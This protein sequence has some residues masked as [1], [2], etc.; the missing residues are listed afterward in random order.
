MENISD[1]LVPSLDNAI[2]S[3]ASNSHEDAHHA[4]GGQFLPVRED[5]KAGVFV[6]GLTE[7]SLSPSIGIQ[8]VCCLLSASVLSPNRHLPPL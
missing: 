1:L 7:V 2:P 5:P 8:E 4:R 6:E 3:W